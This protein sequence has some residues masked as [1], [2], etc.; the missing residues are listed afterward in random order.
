[1]KRAI[2]KIF[3]SLDEQ[4]QITLLEAAREGLRD[5]SVL[6]LMDLTDEEAEKVLAPLELFLCGDN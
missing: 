6:T 2:T 3:N 5:E 1:M 4:Q